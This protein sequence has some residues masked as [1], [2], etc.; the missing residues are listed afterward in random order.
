MQAD[1]STVRFDGRIL[2]LS[3]SADVM[4]RQIGGETITQA[5]AGVLRDDVSTDEITPLPILTHY[6]AALGRYP[7]TGFRA[8]DSLPIAADA[9]RQGGFQ[10]VVAGKRYGKG[11]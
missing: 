3:Q 8:G 5:Q 7:Y 10:V 6:D 2:F 4:Q 1:S 11:S 9:V